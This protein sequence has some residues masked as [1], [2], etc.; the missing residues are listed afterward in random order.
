MRLVAQPDV[1][2][3][4]GS[5]LGHVHE[6]LSRK[7]EEGQKLD[8]RSLMEDAIKEQ[9]KERQD[10]ERKLQRLAKSMDHLERAK[11]EEEVPLIEAAYKLKM[12]EDE[13]YHTTMQQQNAEK[14]R[15][16]WETNVEEKKR[17]AKMAADKEEFGAAIVSRRS[18][19]FEALR[20]EREERI[21][22]LRALRRAE[23]EIARRR[24]YIRRL[25][26]I[27]D[28]VR[29]AA[30]QAER[31]RVE[32]EARARRAAE[33][34]EEEKRRDGEDRARR[35]RYEPRRA[36]PGPGDLGGGRL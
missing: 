27:E 12:A 28:E 14:H 3:G 33:Q 15:Q 24:A 18:E 23:R 35:D 4:E 1:D 10:M 30:E 11:R 29:A 25:Q 7:L 13:Q 22:E 32:E 36:G 6:A 16:T 2:G 17:L 21:N 20:L 34:E 8:K 9:I 19:E 26:Q 31:E 5:G